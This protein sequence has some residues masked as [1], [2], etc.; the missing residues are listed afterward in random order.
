MCEK[1]MM[2][3]VAGPGLTED[4]APLE[5]EA[6]DEKNF[7]PYLICFR[8]GSAMPWLRVFKMSGPR[9]ECENCGRL[10]KIEKS[11]KRIVLKR[12]RD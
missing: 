3:G 6:F 9:Y 2:R 1:S 8:C 4:L 10:V 12:G 11:G 5:P 7:P